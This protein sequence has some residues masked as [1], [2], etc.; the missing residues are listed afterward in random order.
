MPVGDLAAAVLALGRHDPVPPDDGAADADLGLALIELKVQALKADRLADPQAGGRQ[1]FE[2]GLV[3]LGCH[4]QDGGELVAAKDLD[5]FL[6]QLLA[7]GHGEALG[8]VVA[9]QPLALGGRQRCTQRDHG[10]GDRAVAEALALILLVGQPV[11]EAGQRVGAH[12]NQLQLPREVAVRVGAD[13]A[14][15]FL[16]GVLAET[17]PSLAAVALDP[18]IDVA[19]EAD[20]RALLTLAA[21]AVG[22]ALALDPLRLLVGASVALS[23]PA[24]AAENGDVADGPALAV[25]ALEDAGRLGL[26]EPPLVAAAWIGRSLGP[27]YPGKRS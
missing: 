8:W 9:D 12:V 14:A 1:K 7:V 20:R 6:G 18:F 15:V 5:L 24:G 2:E 22:L 4:R 16:A 19:E 17:S 26:P 27:T 13:Q 23:L 10:V 25:N 11:H 3:A 21:V